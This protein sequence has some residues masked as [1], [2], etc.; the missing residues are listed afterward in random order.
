[1]LHGVDADTVTVT[2]LRYGGD[3]AAM[4]V[5]RARELPGTVWG[6]SSWFMD[7]VLSFGRGICFLGMIL[8][9]SC[10]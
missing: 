8:R 5:V 9:E 1:L 2:V 6:S 7:V 3:G 4:F 10:L